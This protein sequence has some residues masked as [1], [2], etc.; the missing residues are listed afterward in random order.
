[1]GRR[2]E[3]DATLMEYLDPMTDTPEGQLL[4]LVRKIENSLYAKNSCK[5]CKNDDCPDCKKGGAVKKYHLDPTGDNGV[6]QFHE[7][8][9]ENIRASGFTTNQAI[10]T[11]N[12]GP[13]R[14]PISE[15]AKM[16]S[17]S[18][19]G[20]DA[21]SS[22]LHMHLTNPGGTTDNLDYVEDYLAQI[23]KEA[24]VG[25]LGVVDEIAGLIE[26]IYTRL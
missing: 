8:S 14:N 18:Q 21:K 26:K 20:Y 11:T 22:S 25:Q 1:M 17:V 19:T 16:P 23:R 7:V 4:T 3:G 24:D 6:P 13:S 12:D 5:G 10:P 2:G 9:G 15:V